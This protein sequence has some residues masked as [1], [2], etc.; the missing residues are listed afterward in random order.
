[1]PHAPNK[2]RNVVLNV[3]TT[4]IFVV[5]LAFTLVVVALTLTSHGGEVSIFGWKPYVV[6]SDSMK[7]V[8]QAGDVAVSHPVDVD[9]VQPGDIITFSSIDPNSYGEAVTHK[10]RELTEYEGEPAFITYGTTTGVDDAYPALAQH[11]TGEF[12]FA[13]PGA[14]HI[15]EF[16]KSPMGY[17]VLVLIPFSVFIGLQVRN[18]VRLL[19]EDKTRRET[20]QADQ[21]EEQRKQIEF[22]QQEIERLRALVNHADAAPT[23]TDAVGVAGAMSPSASE[24]ARQVGTRVVADA[25]RPRTYTSASANTPVPVETS[26]STHPPV[27]VFSSDASVRASRQNAPRQ[28]T[29]STHASSIK[30]PRHAAVGYVFEEPFVIDSATEEFSAIQA[31]NRGRHAAKTAPKKLYW[32]GDVSSYRVPR[33]DEL[34]PGSYSLK[35]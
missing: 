8:F 35:K 32:N 29:P 9:S 11:V 18:F 20:T 6:L 15:F 2:T 27:S 7:P 24:S 26:V 30:R 17:V 12:A 10:V 3:V 1:M 25:S 19:K 33:I 14:G 22:M 31:A 16:F 23:H 34:P 5:A 21:L 28:S 4:I 13:I